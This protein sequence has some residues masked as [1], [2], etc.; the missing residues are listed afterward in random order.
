MFI[1]GVLTVWQAVYTCSVYTTGFTH[2]KELWIL[3]N[4][5]YCTE[6]TKVERL[7]N[8]PQQQREKKPQQNWNLYLGSSGS[9]LL[10][11]TCWKS[12]PLLINFK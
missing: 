7:N 2:L 8:L 11:I 10:S 4:C 5:P 9:I 6:D 12:L 1:Q 3:C